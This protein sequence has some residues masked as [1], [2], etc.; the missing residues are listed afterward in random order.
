MVTYSHPELA[1]LIEHEYPHLYQ[2]A[3][4]IAEAKNSNPA[5]PCRQWTPGDVLVV[6]MSNGLE[7][8]K[9]HCGS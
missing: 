4:E 8:M 2:Q 7:E 5:D 1:E 6:A 3:A 9:R